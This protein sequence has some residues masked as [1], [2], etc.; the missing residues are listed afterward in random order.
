MGREPNLP[1]TGASRVQCRNV[2]TVEAKPVREEIAR[3]IVR[4]VARL[5]L[6][7]RRLITDDQVG[8]SRTDQ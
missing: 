8:D 1:R 6:L 3:K 5:L 4:V 7:P 2:R